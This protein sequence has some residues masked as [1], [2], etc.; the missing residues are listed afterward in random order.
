MGSL[1]HQAATVII[2]FGPPQAEGTGE[3][4]GLPHTGYMDTSTSFF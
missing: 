3:S 4:G 2:T 1:T